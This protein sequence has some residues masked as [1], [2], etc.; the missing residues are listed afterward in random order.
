MYMSVLAGFDYNHMANHM[1]IIVETWSLNLP[2]KLG[3][4]FVFAPNPML[5]L[6]ADEDWC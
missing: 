6:L 2:L 4:V 3:S 1:N 5:P